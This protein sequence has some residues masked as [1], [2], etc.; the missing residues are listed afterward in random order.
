MHAANSSIFFISLTPVQLLNY[1]SIS[2]QAITLKGND[3]S[4][5]DY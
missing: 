1:S 4:H 5:S 3:S 2:V